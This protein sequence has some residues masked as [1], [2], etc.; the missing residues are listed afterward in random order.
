MTRFIDTYK[1][2]VSSYCLDLNARSVRTVELLIQVF[3]VATLITLSRL[4][5]NIVLKSL[6][7]PYRNTFYCYKYI[8]VACTVRAKCRTIE[9][10]C[11]ERMAS[12]NYV[13]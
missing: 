7:E 8:I 11:S 1:L 10:S 4:F 12:F 5:H 2:R 3:A 9:V 13:S 6:T